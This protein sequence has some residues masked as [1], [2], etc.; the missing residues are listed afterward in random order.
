MLLTNHCKWS[1]CLLAV[2][3]AVTT[4]WRTSAAQELGDVV[5][6]KPNY[7]DWQQSAAYNSTTEFQVRGGLAPFYKFINIIL[8]WFEPEPY[9]PYIADGKSVREI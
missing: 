1:I 3:L 4:T 2:V 5:V 7:S 9:I 6:I 8:S